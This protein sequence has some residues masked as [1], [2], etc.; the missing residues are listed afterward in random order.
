MNERS[1]ASRRLDFLDGLRGW[2]S[3][4]VV[5]SHLWGQ[6]ARHTVDIYSSTAMRLVSDGHFAV[7]IFF[8]LSG[9]ALSLRFVRQPGPFAP[10][11]LV[12]ARYVRLVV[13]IAA[14]TLI[15]FTL[16]K[17]QWY[18]SAEAATAA[19]S[20]IFLG[21]RQGMPTTFADALQFSATDAL[22][23]Y[24]PLR[25]FNSSLWTMPVEFLGSILVYAL[26]FGLSFLPTRRPALR[27][28]IGAALGLVLAA[29]GKPLAACF[30][31]GYVVAEMLFGPPRLLAAGAWIGAVLV[32]A[33]AALVAQHGE[34]DDVR[35][36]VLA[37]GT[38]M[39]VACWPTLRRVLSTR[40]SRWLGTISF[41]LYLIHT[42]VIEC[43]GQLYV[44]LLKQGVTVAP[45]THLT[46]AIALLA[47]LLAA[48]LL[49]PVEH[50][51]IRWS[52]AVGRFRLRSRPTPA[53]PD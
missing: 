40:L 52:R 34:L 28:A 29:V 5:L 9:T 41:P 36:A 43:C 26:L 7:L 53:V 4:M 31:G 46:V 19:A 13:P 20:P 51:S 47:C 6:F 25:S 15:I 2:A 42:A 8:V 21:P 45:A 14:T 12:A 44:A 22:F 16:M 32:A 1:T 17:L 38:V 23:H 10:G 48:R 27:M 3:L 37:L 11:W 24:D 33:G 30:C 49:M 39:C 50:L 18:G 35:G